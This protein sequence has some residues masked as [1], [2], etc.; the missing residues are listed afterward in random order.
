[1]TLVTLTS[2]ISAVAGLILA[3]A[4]LLQVIRHFHRW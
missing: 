4:Q 2:L 1:M 3:I